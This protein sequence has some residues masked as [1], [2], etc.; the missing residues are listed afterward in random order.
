LFGHQC[1]ESQKSALTTIATMTYIV[2]DVVAAKN[3]YY[4]VYIKPSV[5]GWP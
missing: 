1:P 2:A 4:V 3:I 5:E